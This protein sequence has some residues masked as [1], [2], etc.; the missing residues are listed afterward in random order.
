M[1]TNP[2][3]DRDGR[4]GTDSEGVTPAAGTGEDAP[5]PITAAER[6][7]FRAAELQ[8][9]LD[10]AKARWQKTHV[11]LTDAVKLDYLAALEV[12][13]EHQAASDFVGIDSRTARTRRTKDKDFQADC[14]IALER[15]RNTITAEV[16]RRAVEGWNEPVY[17][18]GKL[19]GYKHVASDR[20]MEMHAKRH[21]PEYRDK[22][23]VEHSGDVGITTGVLVIP[24]ALVPGVTPKLR[25]V[26]QSEPDVDDGEDPQ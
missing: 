22:F 9:M 15:H 8:R 3:S 4:P 2:P 21:V 23:G 24:T 12:T 1:G 26:E 5:R 11:A 20:M 6:D 18:G 16:R 17:Q 25:K 13:G 14:E 7:K 10:V 19:V